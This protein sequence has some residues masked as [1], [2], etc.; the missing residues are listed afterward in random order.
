MRCATYVKESEMRKPNSKFVIPS[1]AGA[2]AL[3]LAC[4]CCAGIGL[5]FY[6]DQLFGLNSPNTD[7]PATQSV[8]VPATQSSA[9]SDLPEWTIISYSAADD[10]VLEENMCR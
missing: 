10:D 2:V 6:G 1:I 9:D 5:Y 8:E 3:C 4:V 7:V